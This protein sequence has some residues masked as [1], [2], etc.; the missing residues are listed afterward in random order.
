M[1]DRE[2]ELVMWSHGLDSGISSITMAMAALRVPYPRGSVPLDPSDF[3][4]CMRMLERFPWVRDHFDTIAALGPGWRAL[5][6]QWDEL[7]GLYRRDLA[8]GESQE[9]WVR[10]C[11]LDR[12]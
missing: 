6:D 10:L 11:A 7:E 12:R 9:L 5:I 1:T 3:G 8:S 4:R 2:A